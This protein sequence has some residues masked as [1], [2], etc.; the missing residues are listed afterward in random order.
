M[1]KY[2]FTLVEVLGVIG[3]I[4]VIM[5]ISFGAYTYAANSAKEKATK[6]TIVRLHNAL[7]LL[8]DKGFLPKTNGFVKI[9]VDSDNLKLKIDGN[10]VG[11][12]SESKENYYKK[13][14]KRFAGAMDAESINALLD[15]DGNI[16]DS[17]ETPIYICFPGKFNKGGID[18]ISAG[19]DGGFGEDAAAEPVTDIAKYKDADGDVICDDISNFF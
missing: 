13:V 1:K 11:G 3:L 9:S 8:Q 5:A 12:T 16:C 17:W 6:A 4:A 7:Q 15:N 10:E 18:I 19:G 14:F 2:K